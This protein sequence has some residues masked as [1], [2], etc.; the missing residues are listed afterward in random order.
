SMPPPNTGD[1]FLNL[2]RRSE[3]VSPERLRDSGMAD[4]R[5]TP[6]HIAA[7]LV[8]K[9]LL[10]RFQAEQLLLGKWRGFTI[11]KYR[12][13]ERIGVG[14]NGAVYLCEH[15]V[16]RRKVAIKVLPTNRADSPAALARFYREARAAGAL[17]HPH[18]VKAHDVDEENGLHFL[19]MDYV[20]GANLQDL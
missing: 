12:V 2:L 1:D 17:D 9:G 6:K 19:V 10:T 18:L 14:G 8:S 15:M 20:D 16:V 11:G 5:G 4:G 7:S 13:L 3:L